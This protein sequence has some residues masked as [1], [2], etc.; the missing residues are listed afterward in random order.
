MSVPVLPVITPLILP[1]LKS[2]RSPPVPAVRLAKSANVVTPSMSPS[3]APVMLKSLAV[4]SPSRISSPAPPSPSPVNR[5]TLL[6]VVVITPAIVL[7][8]KSTVCAPV[9]ALISIRS[10]DVSLPLPPSIA[11]TVTPSANVKVSSPSKPLSVPPQSLLI[12]KTSLPLSPTVVVPSFVA[13]AP[14]MISILVRLVATPKLGVIVTLSVPV[15]SKVSSVRLPARVSVPSPPSMPPVI[16]AVAL[17]W[18]TKVSA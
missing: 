15:I 12:L 4:L 7:F 3:S 16:W 8:C 14:S 18:K 6:N 1:P 10:P 17:F 13:L 11:L 5:S 9:H 2:K